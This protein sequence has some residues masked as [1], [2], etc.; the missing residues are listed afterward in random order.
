MP[1][2]PVE[3]NVEQGP[4]VAS[5][6][7]DYLL[8][9]YA[10]PGAEDLTDT[11]SVALA[12][13]IWRDLF[14]QTGRG[15]TTPTPSYTGPASIGSELA[16]LTDE[17]ARYRWPWTVV[18]E[19][20]DWSRVGPSP[21]AVRV[22]S[23]SGNDVP[24]VPV[25]LEVANGSG[26]GVNN[27]GTAARITLDVSPTDR[28]SDITVSA[29]ANGP[30]AARQLGSTPDSQRVLSAGAEA[31]FCRAGARGAVGRYRLD[32]QEHGQPCVPER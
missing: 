25:N 22:V 7:I 3:G 10:R 20:A 27:T 21:A 14:L 15:L 23:A 1:E 26:P 29:T 2:P 6:C 9:R 5:A 11:R 12:W 31:Q 19:A 30:G 24:N 13:Y 28:C 4:I 32:L 8:W 18:V 17:A 16:Q